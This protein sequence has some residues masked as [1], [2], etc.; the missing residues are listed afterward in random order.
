MLTMDYTTISVRDNSFGH[1]FLTR[2][3]RDVACVTTNYTFLGQ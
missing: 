2:A 3:G 1:L